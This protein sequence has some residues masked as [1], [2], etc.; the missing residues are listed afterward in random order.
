[1]RQQAEIVHGSGNIFRDLRVENAD[2]EQLK[3]SLAGEIIKTLDRL[4]MTGRE[5]HEMTGVSAADFSRLRNASLD[6]FTIDRL[7]LI[8]SRL[9][10]RVEV[11]IKV[12][13]AEA[14]IE[15]VPA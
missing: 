6:R 2:A 8:L 4:G 10:S 13:R 12:R 3:A 14:L 11:K 5:A 15:R 9:G 7:M 1:M